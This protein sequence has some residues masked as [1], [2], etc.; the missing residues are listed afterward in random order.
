MIYK[1]SLHPHLANIEVHLIQLLNI[2]LAGELPY[3][4]REERCFHRFGHNFAKGSVRAIIT[5][6]A[7]FVLLPVQ[8]PKKG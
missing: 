2:D 7:D 6:D 5:E 4:D 8:R 1:R 3:R